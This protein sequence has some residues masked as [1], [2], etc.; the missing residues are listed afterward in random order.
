MRMQLNVAGLVE[1]VLLSAEELLTVYRP[2]LKNLME[3]TYPENRGIVFLAGPPG[4]GKSTFAAILQR[5]DREQYQKDITILPM[6]GFHLSNEYLKNNFIERDGERIC[7]SEIKGAPES[8]DLD[9][10]AKA[11][12]SLR[13][14]DKIY[15]PGYD[16]TIHDVVP[17]AIAI[18]ESGLFIVEGNYLLLDEPGWRELVQYAHK[19]IFLSGPEDLLMDRLIDRHIR[20]GK[21]AKQAREWVN[22]TDMQNIQRV[23]SRQVP[24]DVRILQKE[25]GYASVD[26]G[27]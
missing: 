9:H 3:L 7:L 12:R 15:W 10:F 8:F 20:G 23:I 14:G 4:S 22:R 2:V 24:A 16:R 1:E 19:T 13:N 25:K 6:D 27:S 26:Y 5:L 17:D 18:S 11:L 21:K